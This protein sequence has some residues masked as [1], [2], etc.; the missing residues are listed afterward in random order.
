MKRKV[1]LSAPISQA[2]RGF[3]LPRE[4]LLRLLL[5]LHE[6]LSDSYESH[7]HRRMKDNRK[8]FCRIIVPGI[9]EEHL[10]AVVID[11][12]TSPDHFLIADIGYTTR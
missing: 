5:E 3:G 12:T 2:I 9:S 10:F 4:V 1:V 8:F 11:D 6:G 7:R